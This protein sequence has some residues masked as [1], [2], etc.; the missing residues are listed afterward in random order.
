MRRLICR[1]RSTA[2]LLALSIL[3]IAASTAAHA[4]QSG[5]LTPAPSPKPQINGPTIYGVHPGH[6][7]LYRIPA[8]GDRTM[9][10]SAK[11]L[12]KGLMLDP[13]TGIL[14]GVV[15]RPGNYNLTLQARNSVG[16]DKRRFR[17][18]AGD[19]I[20]LTPPMGWST[21][22]MVHLNISDA[23]VRQQP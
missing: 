17:I 20:A 5:I 9:T 23:M 7:L 3:L 10:F 1:F 2:G 22:Y 21:W 12:P 13:A 18:V 6:P 19:K 8:T 16:T 15:S 11:G 4:Q 14:R